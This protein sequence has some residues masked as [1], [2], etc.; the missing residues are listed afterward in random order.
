MRKFLLLQHYEICVISN[1]FIIPQQI[2]ECM[3]WTSGDSVQTDV[4]HEHKP[5][6]PNDVIK[7]SKLEDQVHALDT[8]LGPKPALTA[9]DSQ[10]PEPPSGPIDREASDSTPQAVDDKGQGPEPGAVNGQGLSKNK[11]EMNGILMAGRK[12]S[13]LPRRRK[14]EMPYEGQ[15]PAMPI[16]ISSTINL[17][18]KPDPPSVDK[19]CPEPPSAPIDREA[20]DSKPQAVDD[21]G[22]EP[23]ATAVNG[24][25]PSK[26]KDEMN[27]ILMAAVDKQCPEPPSA[28]I[29]REASDSKP[30]AVD[31]KGQGPEPG[32]VNGQG[33]SKNK[34]EMNDGK[35]SPLPRQRKREMPYEGQVPAL[36]TTLGPQP[37]LPVVDNLCSEPPSGAIL[38]INT[39]QKRKRNDSPQQVPRKK[40]KMHDGGKATGPQPELLTTMGTA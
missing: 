38:L 23:E 27:G 29:D 11:N 32:A 22:P 34:D 36:G 10:C 8:T 39:G 13:P 26:N 20:S 5:D 14:R 25:G 2:D 15:V 6:K 9:V 19:Q 30:Q 24:Q 33:L 18:P 31:D 7:P 40:M 16:N 37:A 3:D 17:G 4:K 35:G 12:G 21:E 1:F 28:P